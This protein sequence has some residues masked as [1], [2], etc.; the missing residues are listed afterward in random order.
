MTAAKPSPTEVEK[1]LILVEYGQLRSEQHARIQ[2]R[3]GLVYTTPAA[4]AA[5]VAGTI[6]QRTAA[7]L[8]LLLVSLIE[9]L[10]LAG[11]AWLVVIAT[12]GTV[13]AD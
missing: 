1:E 5:V 13:S 9:A 4:M 7:I 12:F 2:Q 3:D 11:L 10:L 6:S 8:L